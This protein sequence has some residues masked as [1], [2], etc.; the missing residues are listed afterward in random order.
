[1]VGMYTMERLTDGKQFDVQIPE[2]T[3]VMPAMLN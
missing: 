3:L 2:F 1:M